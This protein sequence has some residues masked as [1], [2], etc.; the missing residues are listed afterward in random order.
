MSGWRHR[1]IAWSLL[2]LYRLLFMNVITNNKDLWY[3][4]CHFSEAEKINWSQ[5]KKKNGKVER[6]FRGVNCYEPVSFSEQI[7]SL[8]M[9]LVC[10]PFVQGLLLEIRNRGI[11]LVIYFHGNTWIEG[12]ALG[13][14]ATYRVQFSWTQG[15]SKLVRLI[16][17]Y[18]L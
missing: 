16:S 4:L 9:A 6:V 11:I 5:K 7:L 17:S 10:I 8:H 15:L 2:V 3:H 12:R 14:F 1:Y 18:L 13:A